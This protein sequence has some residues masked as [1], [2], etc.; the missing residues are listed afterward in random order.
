MPQIIVVPGGL[1]ANTALQTKRGKNEDYQ[2][3]RTTPISCYR[4]DTA[5]LQPLERSVSRATTYRS[6]AEV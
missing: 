4:E 3:Y 6:C 2:L 1:F 5:P